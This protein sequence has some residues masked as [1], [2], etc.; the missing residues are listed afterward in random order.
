MNQKGFTYLESVFALCLLILLL[1]VIDPAMKAMNESQK[2]SASHTA[3]YFLA[4]SMIEQWKT[5]VIPVAS[6]E[7]IIDGK[8]YKV[9]VTCTMVTEM[10]E[11]CEVEI[12]WEEGVKMKTLTLIGYRFLPVILP[13]VQS[14]PASGD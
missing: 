3:G 14:L 10:V 4:R 2:M 6:Q 1:A 5:K 13:Q 9:N 12:D 8:K 7:K 11:K